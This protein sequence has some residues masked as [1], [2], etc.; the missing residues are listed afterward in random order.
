ML[1]EF[2]GT[3]LFVGAGKMGGAILAGLLEEG[4]EPTQVTVQDPSP[5]EEIR[6]F[7]SKYEIEAVTGVSEG[8]NPSIVILCVKP[9]IMDKVLPGIAKVINSNTVIISVAAG[10]KLSNFEDALGADKAIVR[11]MPNTPAEIG[12]AM[13]VLCAN[14]NTS[15]ENRETVGALM[16]AI[17]E[18]A[19][20]EN[21][22]DMD[23][24][25]ALSGSGP[26]YIFWLTECMAQA[27]IKAGLSEDLAKQ[28][29]RATVSGAAELMRHSDLEPSRLRENVTSPNGTTAAALEVLMADNGLQ[30][31]MDNAIAAA[32]KR[33]KELS[34]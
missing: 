18:T 15:E 5:P 16:S 2:E 33:S 14:K 1:N 30:P 24:V 6:E 3:I 11:A 22:D 29:A 25:T 9:Q 26:A 32:T 23:A 20:T 4:V 34:A 21:E 19:W 10:K 8:F 17:G 7:L 13:T 12:R 27:G 31:I 28:L